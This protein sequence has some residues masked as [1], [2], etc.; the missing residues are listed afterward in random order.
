MQ[1]KTIVYIKSNPLNV[2]IRLPKEMDAVKMAGYKTKLIYWDRDFV[3][4][5]TK[6]SNNSENTLFRMKAPSGV[7]II[8]FL[9]IWWV[10]VFFQLLKTN[11]EIIHVVNFDSVFPALIAGKI[12]RTPVIY[13]ILDV[14]VDEII[15]PKFVRNF[16]LCIDKIFMHFADVIIVADE[17]QIKGIGGIPNKSIVTIYDSPPGYNANNYISFKKCGE[18][19]KLFFAGVLYKSRKLNLDKMVM[20]IKDLD[21]VSLIIAGYGD[22]VEEIIKWTKEMPQKITYLGKINYKEVIEQGLR[23]DLFFVLRDPIVPANSY[24][25]GSILFN[26]MLCGK[27]LLVNK[28]SSTA[29]KVFEEKCGFVVDANNVAEVRSAI[30]KLR[31]NPK[32]CQEFGSNARQAYATKYSWEVMKEKLLHLY[33]N[34]AS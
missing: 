8:F 27:P 15:V 18:P 31:D 29:T 4:N 30:I 21:G 10:F 16:C 23:A 28:G 19:F 25:C 26:A 33:D 11:F 14:Y 9:P 34:L 13:E 7:R 20:A 17:A 6:E 2:D 22:M 5:K 12:K 3:A 32:L 1:K 24:T